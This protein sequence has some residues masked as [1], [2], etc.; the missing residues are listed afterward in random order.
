MNIYFY[1]TSD[2]STGALGAP[3]AQNHEYEYEHFLY[4]WKSEIWIFTFKKHLEEAPEPWEHREPREP[5]EPQTMN[6]NFAQQVDKEMHDVWEEVTSMVRCASG[7]LVQTSWSPVN[8]SLIFFAFKPGMRFHCNF[9]IPNIWYYNVAPYPEWLL[10]LIWKVE[11]CH[12][13]KFSSAS[14]FIMFPGKDQAST[15]I[16]KINSPAEISH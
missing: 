10:F 13:P 7:C 1:Y 15:F 6:C 5:R 12:F 14:M 2:K 11:H 4:I 3:G 16:A 9:N 8:S